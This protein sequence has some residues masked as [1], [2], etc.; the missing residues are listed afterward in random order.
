[1]AGNHLQML[2]CIKSGI[3]RTVSL[4]HTR[5][6]P[7]CTL[8]DIGEWNYEEKM[9]WEDSRVYSAVLLPGVYSSAFCHFGWTSVKQE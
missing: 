1:M 2:H 5:V 8:T 9:E 6:S 4:P 7:A 3:C